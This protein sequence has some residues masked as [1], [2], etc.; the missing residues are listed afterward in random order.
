MA[1]VSAVLTPALIVRR[2]NQ[3]LAGVRPG[4]TSPEPVPAETAR[5]QCAPFMLLVTETE[6]PVT[7]SAKQAGLSAEQMKPFGFSWFVPELLRHKALWRGI[8]LAS[9]A[10]QL[11][12]LATPLF[13]RVI[14]DKVI[15]HHSE[16]TLIVL[17]VALMVFMLFT[18]CMSW[19]RQYPVLHTDS[20]I[21]AYW[22]RR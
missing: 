6:P 22:T 16:S 13:T 5:A 10:I 20:R 4:Q 1:N 2:N 17:G 11:V 15:A 19:L 3:T 12:G 18:S 21:N 14:I 9:L 7:E 8:L